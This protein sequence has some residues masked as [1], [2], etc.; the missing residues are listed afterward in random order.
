M[1][2]RGRSG[3]D[4]AR[5]GSRSRRA[6]RLVAAA[7]LALAFADARAGAQAEEALAPSVATL[8][9]RAVS[10]AQRARRLR[11]STQASPWIRRATSTAATSM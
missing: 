5:R 8:L 11:T 4:V 3:D 10:D 1:T 6:V 7:A 2:M 9:S